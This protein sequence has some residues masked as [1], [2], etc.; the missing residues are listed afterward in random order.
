METKILNNNQQIPM[1]GLGTFR[2][3]GDECTNAV[4]SALELGYTHIDTAEMYGNEVDIGKAIAGVDRD[5]LFITSKVWFENLAC[6][7]VIAACEASLEKLGTDYLDLYL[8]H[9][10]K[11]G[12]DYR[13]SFRGFKEL[14][15]RGLIKAIGVSNFNKARLEESIAICN[16]L[17]LSISCNQ[18]EFHLG[19]YQQELL[20]F[21]DAN[22]VALTAYCPVAKG[23]PVGGEILS[24]IASTYGKT[25]TQVALRWLI[26]KGIVAIPKSSNRERQASNFDVFDFE[27]SA[28]EMSQLDGLGGDQRI[29]APDWAEF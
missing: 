22:G 21:C 18:V 2:M 17:D 15:Q 23:D 1:L 26:Q 29:V 28:A 27:L 20:E 5:K 25:P 10:P 4:H 7:D 3:T 19:L 6:D 11:A 8:I 9:W 12:T 14:Q 24:G 16:E 13:D